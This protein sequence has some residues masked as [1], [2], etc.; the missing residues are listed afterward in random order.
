M[1]N[2]KKLLSCLTDKVSK[3]LGS[4]T[5]TLAAI[6]YGTLPAQA[7]NFN[8][9]YGSNVTYEQKVST[10]L[11]ANI[12][13]NHLADPI[14]V[15]IHVDMA[16]NSDLPTNVIGG[17]LPAF[18]TNYNYNSFYNKLQQDRVSND[19]YSAVNSLDS[20]SN[21]YAWN[22]GNLDNSN[23]INMT[24]ANAKAIGVIDADNSALD[25]AIVMNNLNGTGVS[26]QYD[27]LSSAVG[28]NQLDFTSVM[29]HEIGHAL[30]FVSSLDAYSY[31]DYHSG[32][33]EEEYNIQDDTGRTKLRQNWTTMDLFRYYTT[34]N[35]SINKGLWYGDHSYKYSLD[36]DANSS[37]IAVGGQNS[38]QYLSIDG[39]TNSLAFLAN[40][41]D[42]SIGGDGY[43]ASHYRNDL[44]AG[45]MDPVLE[46]N[47]R[48][49]LESNGIDLRLFDAI[50]WDRQS[51]SAD[52]VTLQNNAESEVNNAANVD[53][54]QV[55]NKLEELFNQ[56]G[57]GG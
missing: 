2:N 14:T 48:R 36:E 13:S 24:R 1:I 37:G 18:L 45:I 50:G 53:N 34:I 29:I 26:W 47:T 30:G 21:W 17:S 52:L 22:S 27:Y 28:S 40:G 12:W 49:Y 9:T 20:G 19:D 3:T 7:V 6:G 33:D 16:D 8:I 38:Y 54:N 56:Y 4:L 51:G 41:S 25:A 55:L 31:T 44:D 15:N 5:L 10:K 35:S 23:T 11:A 57:W 43:Q 39:G 32:F 42:T 46:L